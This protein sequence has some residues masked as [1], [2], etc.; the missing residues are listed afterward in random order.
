MGRWEL[1]KGSSSRD[2]VEEVCEGAKYE[3]RY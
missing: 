2:Q 3:R 1:G